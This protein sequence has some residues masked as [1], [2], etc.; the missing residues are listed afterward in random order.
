MR[1]IGLFALSILDVNVT[2]AVAIAKAR[3]QLK[4]IGFSTISVILHNFHC[5]SHRFCARS[6]WMCSAMRCLPIPLP[7][8]PGFHC[9]HFQPS[10]LSQFIRI[11]TISLFSL[12]ELC[13]CAFM[14]ARWR[15]EGFKGSRQSADRMRGSD[16]GRGKRARKKRRDGEILRWKEGREEYSSEFQMRVVMC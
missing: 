7:Q 13:L 12:S 4:I 3:I 15:N 5:V 16:G 11:Q 14:W 6:A 2:Y 9:P 10:L 1:K 8:L